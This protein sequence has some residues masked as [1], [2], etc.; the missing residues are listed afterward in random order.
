M[1]VTFQHFESI[2]V[3]EA[4]K[5]WVL[6][7]N[8]LGRKINKNLID[9]ALSG[10]STAFGEV[11]FAFRAS[12]YGFAY[13]MLR[14]TSLAEDVTQEVFMFLLENPQ[15]FEPERGELLSFLCGIA[16]RKIIQHLR[17]HSTRFEIFDDDLDKF[18][19][20]EKIENSPL[21]VLLNEELAEKI[22]DLITELPPLVREVLILREFEHLSYSEISQITETN[23]GLVKTRLYR[24][25]KAL[26]DQLRPYL[27]IKKDNY[28][29]VY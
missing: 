19:E 22:E 3:R 18:N 5:A 29:E 2:T 20:I 14:E 28:Y 21:E 15:R 16:R 24:A 11:Y 23:L 25:R 27:A 8:L 13:R 1:I 26:A 12:I 9:Q 4:I 10:D 17:K 7:K 6:E